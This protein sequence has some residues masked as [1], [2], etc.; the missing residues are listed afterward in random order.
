MINLNCFIGML[1]MEMEMVLWGGHQLS[2]GGRGFAMRTKLLE[3]GII[4]WLRMAMF[5][6]AEKHQTPRT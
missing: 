1:E 4:K 5:V 6:E 3:H 2:H